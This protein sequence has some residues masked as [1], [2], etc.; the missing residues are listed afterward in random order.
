M[1]DRLPN[2]VAELKAAEEAA[3]KGDA[4]DVA[5]DIDCAAA[6]L[7]ANQKLDTTISAW[8]ARNREQGKRWACIFCGLLTVGFN[9]FNWRRVTK[10]HCA[11]AL[12]K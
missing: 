6:E 5:R 3:R 9:L 1:S 10:D 12:A 2:T 8:T 11:E 4:Y 7:L